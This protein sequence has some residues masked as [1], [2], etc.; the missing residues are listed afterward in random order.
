V[1]ILSVEGMKRTFGVESPQ[2]M[3]GHDF[4]FHAWSNAG[5]IIQTIATPAAD[6]SLTAHFTTTVATM[7]KH[8][9]EE[10]V[11]VFPNPLS[12]DHCNLVY[13]VSRAQ[14]VSIQ[15][16]NILGQQIFDIRKFAI[17]GKHEVLLDTSMAGPG[18]YYVIVVAD[19]RRVARK[20]IVR[21]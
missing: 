18:I 10:N 15:F 8:I 12:G 14:N 20:I 11:I 7:D 1:E 19:E 3:N 2:I 4:E 5:E 17:A 21:K 9:V 6:M 13:A 16:V